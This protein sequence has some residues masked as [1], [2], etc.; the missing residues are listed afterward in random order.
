[1]KQSAIC[2]T[3]A[4]LLVVGFA[5][6]AGA[7]P[8]VS[9]SLPPTGTVGVSM[10]GVATVSGTASAGSG[11]SVDFLSFSGSGCSGDATRVSTQPIAGDG[12]YS[13]DPW[14]PAAAGSY[15]WQA[16]VTNGVNFVASECR[17]T[18]V[19]DPP[20]PPPPPPPPGPPPPPPGPPPPPPPP[21][22]AT[23]VELDAGSNVASAIAWSQATSPGAGRG[24]V[25]LA[26]TV[27]LGR[28]DVSADSLASGG[29]QGIL[30]APLLLTAP[31]ALDEATAE[32][33]ERLGAEEVIL[34]GGPQALSF[35]V[36]QALEDAGYDTRRLAG[37][38]RLET[39]VEIAGDVAPVAS[40]AV[41]ARA[42]PAAGAADPTQG[43]ADALAG[44]ALASRLEVPLL[45]TETA[46]LS[47]PTADYLAGSA[48]EEVFVLGGPAAVS[49]DVV[50]ALEDLD[51]TVDRLSGATRADTAVAIAEDGLGL[52]DAAATDAIAL[53]DG[54]DEDA[55]AD[56][57]P[58]ALLASRVDLALLLSND[59]DLPAATEG[60]LTPAPVTLYCG[61]TVAAQACDTAFNLLT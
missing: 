28:D 14:T 49:D 39:A 40:Q 46:Q 41:L 25:P 48:I 44:G 52:E 23:V 37:A 30:D 34:L 12:E 2:G 59:A 50:D 26:A 32:E 29:A 21:T 18:E 17:A 56:A 51:I 24:A 36:V 58:A 15:S 22:E 27:L 3:V 6:P 38:S 16:Y 61:S 8:S 54:Q 43:F 1:M 4:V 19:S 33:L 53:V 55:W 5:I 13:S 35:D 31:D 60:F 42:F 20:P 11:L 57:F 10:V 47:V 7:Q 45:L 9:L